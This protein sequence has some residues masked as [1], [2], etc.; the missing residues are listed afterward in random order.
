MRRPFA[1]NEESRLDILLQE[2]AQ[3]GVKVGHWLQNFFVG[4]MYPCLDINYMKRL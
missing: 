4:F 1:E 3:M 2:R